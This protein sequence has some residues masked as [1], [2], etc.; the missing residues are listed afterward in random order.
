M[1]EVY[2]SLPASAAEA[3]LQA[4]IRVP[5]GLSVRTR[6]AARRTPGVAPGGVRQ[7]PR[8]IAC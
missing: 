3:R 1:R 4:F 5:H 6:Q 8:L 2:R 7:R